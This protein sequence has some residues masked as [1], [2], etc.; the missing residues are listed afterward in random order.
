MADTTEAVY[1]YNIELRIEDGSCVESANSY[2]SIAYAD[3]YCMEH[4]YDTWM[5]QSEY[6]RKAA[7]IKAMDYVDNIFD[8]RGRR[9][10]RDQLLRFPRVEIFDDDRFCYDGIIPEQLKKAVCEAAFYVV[11]QYS[12]YVTSGGENGPLKKDRKKAG[13]TEIEKEYS[14][15][16]YMTIKDILGDKSKIDYTSKYQSLDTMLKGLFWAK[17]KGRIC[18]R[19]RWI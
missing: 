6:V 8:W 5:T 12:L 13:P 16:N 14:K 3:K 1:D 4:N 18:H 9:K 17:G 19:V 15:D 11:E 2:V 10:F 7:I